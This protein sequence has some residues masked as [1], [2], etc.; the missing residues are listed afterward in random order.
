MTKRV[1]LKEDIGKFGKLV[2]G[3]SWELEQTLHGHIIDVDSLGGVYIKDP[4]GVGHLFRS[5]DIISF[6]EME[7]K[8]KQ[9]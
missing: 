3:K 5:K 9:P 2:G 4:S 7:F 6:D 8:P 1:I